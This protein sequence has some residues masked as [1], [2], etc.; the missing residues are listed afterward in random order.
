[1]DKEKI[2]QLVLEEE[3]TITDLIDV[4][5]ELNGIVGVGRITLGE[6]LKNYCFD[7][8][9]V[10]DIDSLRFTLINMIDAFSAGMN[11]G[12]DVCFAVSKGDDKLIKAPDVVTWLKQ[13]FAKEAIK[14]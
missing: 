13:N 7:K 12:S 11:R 2:K 9:A 6:Q 1:V 5:I 10:P 8:V 14:L 4:V 3:L